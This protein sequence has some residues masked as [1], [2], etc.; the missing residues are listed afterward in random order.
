MFE[1]IGGIKEL[2]PGFEQ[3]L[4][5][6]EIDPNLSFSECNYKSVRGEIKTRWEKKNGLLTL[7]VSVPVNTT[8]TV[9]MPGSKGVIEHRIGSGDHTFTSDWVNR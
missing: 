2:K 3:I 8:A 9:R 5:A 4:I 7:S 1:K 6:P